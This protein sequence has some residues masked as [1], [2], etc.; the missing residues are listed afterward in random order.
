MFSIDCH[1]FVVWREL[2]EREPPPE[3]TPASRQGKKGKHCDCDCE[4][5]VGLWASG[6]GEGSCVPGSTASCPKW[7]GSRW[8]HPMAAFDF[9]LFFW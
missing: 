2:G 1:L 4:V 3:D 5:I 6:G 8:G 7:M 9:H